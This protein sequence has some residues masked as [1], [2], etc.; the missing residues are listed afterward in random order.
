[1]LFSCNLDIFS[2]IIYQNSKKKKCNLHTHCIPIGN[3]LFLMLHTH[4]IP[5]CIPI[6][7]FNN[8]INISS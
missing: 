5:I 4:C 7:L 6:P 2:C 8:F 3:I 1:M